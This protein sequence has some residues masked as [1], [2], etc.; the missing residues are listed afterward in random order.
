ML[1]ALSIPCRRMSRI[2]AGGGDE[3][4]ACVPAATSMAIPQ[5]AVKRIAVILFLI[6]LPVICSPLVFQNPESGLPKPS[7]LPPATSH[8]FTGHC[9]EAAFH[10]RLITVI[11][12]LALSLTGVK[13]VP[14]PRL[15]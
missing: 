13:V 11:S 7:F 6:V 1:N 4:P 2:P 8:F 9:C 3:A 14:I 15:T 5:R 12:G 10:V